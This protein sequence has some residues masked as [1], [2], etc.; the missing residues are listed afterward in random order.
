MDKSI[1]NLF[2]ILENAFK[3][4]LNCFTIIF[5]F[6]IGCLITVCKNQNSKTITQNV[7]TP[8]S[9]TNR[10]VFINPLTDIK[11]GDQTWDAANLQLTHFK[12][13]DF[14]L[15]AITPAEWEKAGVEKK[16][17]WCYYQNDSTNNS[18]YGKLYNWYAV[19][20][21]RGLAPS[22][23]H[24]SSD[25]EWRKLINY[26]GGEAFA[27]SKIKCKK[28]WNDK[29]NGTN[30]TGFTALPGGYRFKTGGFNAEGYFGSWWTSTENLTNSAWF[31]SLRYDDDGIY[32]N[33]YGKEDGYA[34][35]CIKN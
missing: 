10:S 17:A 32:R 18:K 5:L 19:N 27:G 29:G 8:D 25:T 21:K 14:I 16:P 13:G 3:M 34:V 20:E 35:R 24:V 4:K 2:F 26:I 15:H 12:N 22:G 11:I 33:N 30:I 1:N 23:W 6:T 7:V 9:D 31:Y 28:G